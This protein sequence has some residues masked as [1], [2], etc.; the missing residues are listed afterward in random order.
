MPRIESEMLQPGWW[1]GE[2]GEKEVRKGSSYEY[3]ICR[4][5]RAP[6]LCSFFPFAPLESTVH[7]FGL[8]TESAH[9]Q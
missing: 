4:S 9:F 7:G 8:S 1:G 3:K 5:W 6:P 2:S